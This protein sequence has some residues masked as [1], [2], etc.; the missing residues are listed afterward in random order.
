MAQDS[1]Q[2]IK[3][4]GRPWVITVAAA[5][6]LLALF[7][8]EA[9]AE[10]ASEPEMR[11]VAQNW[12]A[13]IVYRTGDWA[14]ETNPGIASSLEIRADDGLLLARVYNIEPTGYV[15]VPVLKEMSP[16]KMYSDESNLDEQ[17]GGALQLLKEVLT[18]RL[19]AY[20]A[21]YGSLDA[22][23]PASGG[24]VFDRSQKAAWNRLAVSSKDFRLDNSL[25]TMDEAGPLITSVWHQGA[26]YN[27]LCP[28]GDGDRC[29]V[30]CVATSASQI[31]DYWQWPPNGV[32]SHSYYWGGDDC[33][34][35]YV[36]GQ[37]LSADFSDAYD[38]AN[39]PD[40][41][42]GGCTGDEEAALAELCYEVGVALEMDYG[43]CGSGAWLWTNVFIDYFKY[44]QGITSE[45]RDQHTQESWFALIREE[46]NNDRPIWYNINRHAIVCDGWRDNGEQLEYHMNY[47]WG[48]SHNAWFVLDNLYCYWIEGD[49]CP[50]DEDIMHLNIQPQDEPILGY[51]GSSLA[52]PTGNGNGVAEASETVE[53]TVTIRNTGDD[54]SGASG[55]LSTVDPYLSVVGPSA[56]F[57]P[58]IV[59]GAESDTQTPFTVTISPGCPDPHLAVLDLNLTATGGYST[60]ESFCLFVGSTP[61]FA[62][63]LES[64]EGCWTHY[65][66]ST[67]YADEWHLDTYRSHSS[68]TSWK[69]GGAG[70]ANYSDLL[71]GALVTPPLLLPADAKLDFW[72]WIDAE[73]DAGFTAWDGGIVMISS[74]D[75]QWTQI[76]PEGGYPYSIIDNVDSPFD[77]ATPCYSGSYG[78]SQAFFDLSSYSGV[79]QI[80]FRFG[81][82]RYENREGWYIDDISVGSGFPDADS[83]GVPD[84]SDNCPDYYNPLQL[85]SDGDGI[86][87]GCDCDNPSYSFAG[88]DDF[89]D[90]GNS[91]SFAGDVNNDGYDDVIVGAP[92][93]GD[94]QS[95][96]VYVYSGL[97]GYRLYHLAGEVADDQFGQSVS[98]AGD[99]NSD[100]HHDFLV[101]APANDAAGSDAG[102][103]YVYSGLSGIVLYTLEGEAAGDKFGISVSSAGDANNDT[104]PD[105]L[106]GAHGNSAGG[107]SAGRAYLY[108]GPTGAPLRT[109]TGEAALDQFGR[110]VAGAGDVNNDGYAD[111]IVGAYFHNGATGRA[112]VYSGQTGGL[113]HTFDGEA[114]MDAFGVAVAGLGDINSDNFADVIVGARNNDGAG[115]DAGRAYVYS[116]FDGTILYT[117]SGEHAVDYFGIS[118]A[119]AGDVDDDAVS[120]IIVGAYGVDLTGQDRGTAYIFSGQTGSLLYEFIGEDDEDWFGWSV[121]GGGDTDNDGLADVMVGALLG[122]ADGS[123]EGAAFLYRPGA[124]MDA[125]GLSDACDPD[126]DGDGANNEVD[127]CPNNYNPGQGDADLDGVGD[128]CDNCPDDYNP[129]QIDSDSDGDGV[130]DACDACPGFDDSVDADGDTVPDGCDDCPGYDDLADADGD[131]VPDGCDI[132]P[133]HD[134]LADA[135]DDS[136]PDGCDI[137]PGH[138]DLTD[139]DDDTVPDGCD[140][141]PGYNDFSDG[142]ED[143]VPDGCDACPG[144]DDRHDS[145][146]D[147]VPNGCDICYGFDDLVDP[148]EDGVPSGCDNCPNKPNPDQ[149]DH[150][151]DDIGDV[152]CCVGSVGDANGEGGE[153]PTIGDIIAIIDML[154]VSD[155][156][157]VVA[158]LA[159]AD[160]TQNG[161]ATPEPGDVTIGDVTYLIDYLFVTGE[162]LGLPDCL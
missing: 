33:N 71:D 117:F 46:I 12:T 38:W 138:D 150:N 22:I 111:A 133:G 105:I 139:S 68:S 2:I 51:V 76:Y 36:P 86:G 35:G 98:R 148:D 21:T 67:S 127:N 84:V 130:A 101:G 40:D 78:W 157:A 27:D 145:D 128:I 162:S 10:L 144:Y 92:V 41:C 97:T 57:D 116:G 61:G 19:Q 156:P 60:N 137:C 54:A 23:Q 149:A 45:H 63:D 43:A 11:N 32:G 52:D 30:G 126:A 16:V 132:C 155:D 37:T 18:S 142:D 53:I 48:G 113:L 14:G 58:L 159:E 136:V 13:E 3:P 88:E 112:Y 42:D 39:I 107:M 160:V 44:S 129:D 125:D 152:C 80:M 121:A 20:Q 70:S 108:S 49:V 26:P 100:G 119:G 102:R 75:G 17:A 77:A 15:A 65:T 134:D 25:E 135:D 94:N 5:V 122:D 143:T 110:A 81:T 109:F 47:G 99:L 124:D 56:S 90:F 146:G 6:F 29:V 79:V 34:G 96:E 73:D 59:S 103:V 31:M 50:Y 120:D 74:G 66:Y 4:A 151:D 85:D 158:C 115:S 123:D 55:T 62:D 93:A 104:D 72:Y 118:V 69:V 140:I 131:T 28:M 24:V 154:F 153:K 95:G 82:D 64:G 147:T 8:S 87:D 161:G 7:I 89:A 83:D 106:V 9:P 91:V 141:C 1:N 114:G